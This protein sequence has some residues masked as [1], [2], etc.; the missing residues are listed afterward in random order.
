MVTQINIFGDAEESHHPLEILATRKVDPS[1]PVVVAYGGG[2]NS[3]A[4][5]VLMWRLGIKPDL[6]LFADTG[7][8]LPETYEYMRRFNRWL[9]SVGMPEIVTVRRSRL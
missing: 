4:M 5:L 6:I 2:K 1:M 7:G 8:E 9:A 3:T